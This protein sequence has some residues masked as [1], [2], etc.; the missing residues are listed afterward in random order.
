M[1][2]RISFLFFVTLLLVGIYP[3][4]LFAPTLEAQGEGWMEGW[5]YRKSHVINPAPGAGTDYVIRIV[6]RWGELTQEDLVA[7]AEIVSTLPIPF[8][9]TIISAQA[10][11][12][13]D[14]V[15]LHVWYAATTGGD[16]GDAIYYVKA[17]SPF[18]SW[19][20]PVQVINRDEGIRDPTIFAE[21]NSLYLFLQCWDGIKY[22]PIGLYKVLG[23]ADFTNSNN[24]VYVGVVIDGGTGTYDGNMAASPCVVKI[25]N[26]YYLMYEAF[27]TDWKG[28]IGRAKST[29][30]ESLPW[31]KDGQ[32]KDTNGN[33]IHNPSENDADIVPDTFADQDTL[34]LHYWDGTKWS[35]AYINGDFANN[36]VTISDGDIN[37]QD[38]YSNHASIANIGTIDGVYY[39]LMQ[40]WNDTAYLRLYRSTDSTGNTIALRGHSRTDFGDIR[41]TDDDGVTLLPYWMESKVD[42]DYA[43]F[44]VKVN[45]DLSS[46]LATIYVYYGKSDAITISNGDDTFPLFDD[47]LGNSL[48]SN[49]WTSIVRG[50]GGSVSI[51][52]GEVTLCLNR[53]KVSS[54]SLQSVATFTNDVLIRMKR[55]Y[56][57]GT[58]DYLD[59][60]LG[61]GAEIDE[62]GNKYCWWH[63]TLQNGYTWIYQSI[64][65]GYAGLRRMPAF[66]AY[67][68]LSIDSKDMFDTSYRIHDMVY[69]SSGV[70]KW[71]VDGSQIFSVTDTYF[72]N[73]D[74]KIL[75]S[76]GGFLDGQGTNSTIDYVFVRKYVYLEPTHG[77]WGGEEASNVIMVDQSFVSNERADVRSVQTIG[78]HAK[79][80]NGSD[81]AGGS[82]YINSTEYTTNSTGWVALNVNSP[83]VGKDIWFITGVNCNGVTTYMQTAQA[84][85]IVWDQI[86][87]IEGDTTKEFLTLGETAT[88]WFKAIYEYD[89][90]VFT[91]ASGI[92]SLNRSAMTWSATNTRWEYT[93]TATAIGTA[94]FTISGVY[95]ESHGLTMVNDTIGSQ[96]IYVGSTPFAVISNS[97]ISELTFNST[98]ETLTFKV[99]GPKGTM[100]YTNVTMARTLIGDISELEIYL[101]GNQID[102][103]TTSTEYTWL[104]HITYQHSTHEVV[105]VL[106]SLHVNSSHTDSLK[107]TLFIGIIIATVATILQVYKKRARAD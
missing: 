65:G 47:F 74:K 23:S 1:H 11:A 36:S 57:A 48:D 56:T 60:S 54:V 95:D 14:G 97:T 96:T 28:S 43:V 42:D 81:V 25:G 49:K 59:T 30:I 87:I 20:T 62:N 67:A 6:A 63:T 92:L 88:I 86:K 5:Q 83:F 84:P 78:F 70:L 91:S 77:G 76:Q 106:D 45:D 64:Y 52:N 4:S 8:G 80:N 34:F 3:V 79:W 100:G 2:A 98:S 105:I 68:E 71:I 41:F 27:G 15:Y 32:L 12:Y 35:E 82:I 90:T 38:S 13:W 7:S 58:E 55:K 9:T 26:T 89:N 18:A 99:S 103:I 39:F 51:A 72:L 66:G 24:Y 31:T 107:P 16:I 33:L 46:S 85:S 101:D 40:S 50:D 53:N 75:I 10:A 102:Y 44:W 21:G 22:R 17:S 94:S 104:I 19:S 73:N 93:C 29:N 61:E 37:P 69:T